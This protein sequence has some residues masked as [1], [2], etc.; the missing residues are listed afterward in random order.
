MRLLLLVM[1]TAMSGATL[2]QDPLAPLPAD[3]WTWESAR[4][5]L[6]RAGF[7]GT[8]AE[9]DALY[10]RGLDGAVD[11]LVDYEQQP[12]SKPF[13]PSV[14]GRPRPQ[15]DQSLSPE[16]RREAQ[17][18]ARQMYNRQDRRQLTE[19]RNWWVETMV[20]TQRPLQ[21]KMTL[22]WHGHF[23]SGNRDVRSS[24]H[25]LLQNELLRELATSSI[26]ELVHG[27]AKDPAMLEY[28]DNNKNRRRQP[29]ENFAREV[30]ELF[31]M[32]LGNYSEKDIKEAAR[33]F[34]GWTFDREGRYVFNRRQHDFDEKTVL[35][36]TGR[37]NGDDVIDIILDREVCSQY[38]A[39]KIFR[40]FA[41]E[42][43][44]EELTKALAAQLYRAEQRGD[45]L[46]DYQ[47]KPFLRRLF[48]SAEFYSERSCANHLK[49]P[50]EL[51]V[52]TIRGLELREKRV[53]GLANAMAAQM[54]QTLF[55][56]PNV[57][58]WEQGR[59]WIS[60]STLYHRYNFA[61]LITRNIDPATLGVDDEL[62]E[63]AEEQKMQAPTSRPSSRPSKPQAE[64]SMEDEKA[65]AASNRRLQRR[66]AVMR[67]TLR[68][69]FT[70]PAAKLAR[71]AKSLDAEGIIAHFER[72]FLAVPVHDATRQQLLEALNSNAKGESSAFNIDRGD[73]TKRVARMLHLLF[74]TPEYQVN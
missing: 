73:A 26:R 36:E 71:Q 43:P 20:T 55:Q 42:S 27:I 66:D 60:T 17:R 67:R 56:P 54:G 1:M 34:T 64:P 40:Y 22:F 65:M 50:M 45:A 32:G 39:T 13:R 61:G 16:K 46:L 62:A 63:A 24:F 48:K 53:S 49:S 18:A 10:A 29:N 3:Q 72:L 14:T 41:Y 47:L 23:T 31:T 33:A 69:R 21:E 70:F 28:L 25:M 12:E 8:Q 11:W 7:G 9:I 19:L 68:S 38:L 58:G 59:A 4:H 57:K 44:S 30:M 37:W 6:G 2:A 15:I 74:S 52:G 5:L 51:V 35:G